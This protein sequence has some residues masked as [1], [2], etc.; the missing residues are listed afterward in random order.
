MRLLGNITYWMV[1]SL[2]HFQKTVEDRG[3]WLAAVQCG[4]KELAVRLSHRTA[5]VNHL[6]KAGKGGSQTEQSLIARSPLVHPAWGF[7]PAETGHMVPVWTFRSPSSEP[8][9]ASPG[10]SLRAPVPS[11]RRGLESLADTCLL[12]LK[13]LRGLVWALG[14]ASAGRVAVWWAGSL[15]NL[16]FLL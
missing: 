15:A 4:R 11:G 10:E 13:G 12:L 5:A 14:L 16:Q 3:G 6:N 7:L 9:A 2:S 1:M 8:W